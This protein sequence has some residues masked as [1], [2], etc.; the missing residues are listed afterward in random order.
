ML[1]G[2]WDICI[3][4][5]FGE[6]DCRLTLS[7]DGSIAISHS[8]GTH[9]IPRENVVI[10]NGIKN[11]SSKFELEAPIMTTVQIDIDTESGSGFLC[12]GEFVKT[13]IS[14]TVSEDE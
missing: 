3:E 8:R 5:P 1:L 2:S 13:R 12:I 4:T 11:I 14:C 7:E 9:V 6:E 10:G